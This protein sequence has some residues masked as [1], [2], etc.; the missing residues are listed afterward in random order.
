MNKDDVLT[1]TELRDMMAEASKQ[2]SHLA[3]HAR[4]LDAKT[5]G[6][7]R[8][9]NMVND[10]LKGDAPGTSET[11][12]PLGA[13]T[14]E[15]KLTREQFKEILKKI[16]SGLRALPATA[17]VARQQGSYLA[18]LVASNKVTGKAETTEMRSTQEAFKYG[19][20]VRDQARSG[21]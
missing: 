21:H 17:Q 7:A 6:T 13:I 10:M 16:D 4:F 9:G 14:E 11:T 5:G 2:F 20:K 3:E 1:L 12:G 8:F 15:T 19:H 18:D